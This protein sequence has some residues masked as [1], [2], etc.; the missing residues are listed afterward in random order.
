MSPQLD[1]LPLLTVSLLSWGTSLRMQRRTPQER[2]ERK[3]VSGC[4]GTATEGSGTESRDAGGMRR[5]TK[6]RRAALLLD[7][8]RLLFEVPFLL[9]N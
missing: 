2:D 1:F 5:A 3:A 7:I 4:G 6:R 9:C 8:Q